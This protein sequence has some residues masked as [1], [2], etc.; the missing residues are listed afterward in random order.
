LPVT[1]ATAKSGATAH[2][3]HKRT[4]ALLAVTVGVI[5][6]VVVVVHRS[7]IHRLYDV[8]DS[9]PSF[10]RSVSR[11]VSD[12]ANC[13]MGVNTS[14]MCQAASRPCMQSS[15]DDHAKGRFQYYGS[16][17]PFKKS[18]SCLMPGKMPAGPS[19]QNVIIVSWLLETA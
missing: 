1:E 14:D 4:I 7:W 11:S 5:V 6:V 16:L 2:S 18:S 8:Q 12:L 13:D 19:H 9:T 10:A 3:R 17:A 15:S